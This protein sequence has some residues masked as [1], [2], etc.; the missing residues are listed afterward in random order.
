MTTTI[1]ALPFL[2]ARIALALAF[3][4]LNGLHDA[5][6]VKQAEAVQ[7]ALEAGSSLPLPGTP[8]KPKKRDQRRL[9]RIQGNEGNPASTNLW[10][11]KNNG[12]DGVNTIISN[13]MVSRG[14]GKEISV[15]GVVHVF[16]DIDD[17]MSINQISPLGRDKFLE[18]IRLQEEFVVSKK[19]GTENGFYV[20]IKVST[21]EAP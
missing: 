20:G 15:D 9:S 18:T 11:E 13:M 3:D 5:G 12:R 21:L 6:A 8:Q 1:I 16:F 2:V 10:W 19:S 4:F 7:L 14:H 17:L